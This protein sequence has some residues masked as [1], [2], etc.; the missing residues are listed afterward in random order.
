[1][2]TPGN[3]PVAGQ[4]Y[5]QPTPPP[6]YGQPQGQPYGQPQGQP[7]GQPQPQPYGQP[8]G[9]PAWQAPAPRLRRTRGAKVLTVLGAVVSV[10]SVVLFALGVSRIAEALPELPSD[11]AQS[12]VTVPAGG[13]GEATLS[14]GAEYDLW[15]ATVGSARL[16][17][18]EVTAP[19]GASVTLARPTAGLSTIDVGGEVVARFTAPEDGTYTVAVAAAGVDL[20]IVPGGTLDDVAERVGGAAVLVVVSL[21]VGGLGFCLLLAGGI[22]WG[23]AASNNRRARALGA[24]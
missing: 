16:D 5:G 6:A 22:W 20:T 7:Y 12:I 10:L 2:T 24:A 19:S 18:V 15:A 9:A 4:P 13:S 3:D 17:D 21:L 1:M 23:V 14:A 11:W 8:Y